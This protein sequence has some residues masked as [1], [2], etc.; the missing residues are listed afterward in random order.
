MSVRLAL[1]IDVDSDRGTGLGVANLL[2]DLRAAG[3][4]A[5]FLFSL[6]P[7][8]TGRAITRVLR[9]GFLKKVGRTSIVELYGVRTLLNGTLLPAPHIG[10]RNAA[11]MR[12]VP[13]RAPAPEFPHTW[14]PHPNRTAHR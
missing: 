7:D 5:T 4:P 3:V 14:S 11:G 9:P 6:G 10:R 8:Q 1:K 13:P 12:S 2:A